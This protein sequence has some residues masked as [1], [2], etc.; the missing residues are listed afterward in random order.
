M[1]MVCTQDL[2]KSFQEKGSTLRTAPTPAPV[3]PYA[4]LEMA[5]RAGLGLGEGVTRSRHC[6]ASTLHQPLTVTGLFGPGKTVIS[7][8]TS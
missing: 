3:D 8:P 2:A 4:A 1:S 6:G 7:G 5:R